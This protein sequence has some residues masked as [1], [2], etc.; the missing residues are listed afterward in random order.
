MGKSTVTSMF[1]EFGIPV[2]DADGAVRDFYSGDGAMAI[3]E[4]FPGVRIGGRID[5]ERL[6]RHVLHDTAALKRL[7]RVVHPVVFAARARFVEQAV[8][9][10]RRLVM[11]DVP[12]LFETGGDTAV[13]LIV[14]VSAPEQLQRERALAREGMTETKFNAIVSQQ[15]S[16]SEKRRRAHFIIDT[17]RSLKSTRAQ[18]GQFIRA[19]SGM[20]GYEDR[21]A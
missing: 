21:Y 12:L 5:R 11:V 8:S 4:M 3:E 9:K 17:S 18:I 15:M 6:S 19:A 13:D 7:E 16:D 20:E 2:F 1:R 14:V 10:G